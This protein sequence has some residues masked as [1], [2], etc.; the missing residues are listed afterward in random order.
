MT[1]TF[2]PPQGPF[3]EGVPGNYLYLL[4]SLPD[5]VEVDG[6]G[7]LAW[8]AGA[9]EEKLKAI[10]R[11]GWKIESLASATYTTKNGSS[12]YNY[13]FGAKCYLNDDVTTAVDVVPG[14]DIAHIDS[15]VGNM[16]SFRNGDRT[17]SRNN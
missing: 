4:G 3:G 16:S 12:I 8:L 5:G 9:A 10:G 15:I 6:A 13:H 2:P 7:Q 17:P 1:F 14:A 11:M